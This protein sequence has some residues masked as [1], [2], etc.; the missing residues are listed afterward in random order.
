MNF[1]NF[2]MLLTSGFISLCDHNILCVIFNC[3]KFFLAL[4]S[5]GLWFL[6]KESNPCLLHWKRGVLTTGL[7]GKSQCCGLLV[8]MMG[9]MKCLALR[10]YSFFSYYGSISILSR[11]SNTIIIITVT[12][13]VMRLTHEEHCTIRAN[14]CFHLSM[15]K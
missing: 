3:L 14:K 2:C 15:Q 4:Q 5:V 7:P 6:D 12:R 1:P 9:I 10:S 8:M 13:M 11:T